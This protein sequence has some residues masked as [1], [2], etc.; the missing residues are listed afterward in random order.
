MSERFE[1]LDAAGPLESVLSLGD[2]T[3]YFPEHDGESRRRRFLGRGMLLVGLVVAAC[4]PATSGGFLWTDDALLAQVV[5]LRTADGLRPIWL[6]PSSSLPQRP[7]AMTLVWAEHRFCGADAGG[8]HLVSLLLHAAN[9]LLAWLVLRRLAVPGAWLAAAAWS[10]HPIQVQSLASVSDQGTVLSTFLFLTAGLLFLRFHDVQPPWPDDDPDATA[11][12]ELPHPVLRRAV[13]YAVAVIVFSAALAAGSVAE[14]MPAV[15][16]LVLWWRRGWPGRRKAATTVAAI[17]P[18]FVLTGV[19]VWL[20]GHVGPDDLAEGSA[21]TSLIARLGNI[22]HAFWFYLCKLGWPAGLRVAYPGWQDGTAAGMAGRWL[23]VAAAAGS[24]TTAW[25]FRRRLGEG[26]LVAVVF[27]IAALACAAG[28]LT[29][30][31]HRLMTDPVAYLAV[32]GPIA[33]AVAALAWL[34]GGQLAAQ[35]QRVARLAAVAAVPLVLALLTW[36]RGGTFPDES[37]LW[38]AVLAA[39]PDAPAAAAA[40]RRLGL[41]LLARGQPAAAVDHL[42][43]AVEFNPGHVGAML[44]LAHSLDA[45]GRPDEAVGVF[46]DTPR[47]TPDARIYVALAALEW[48]TGRPD[49]ALRHYA[50]ALSLRPRDA[51]LH[52]DIGVILAEQGRPDEAS[53]HYHAAIRLEPHLAQARINL[54]NVLFRQGRPD[55]AAAQLHEAVRIDPLNFEAFANAA[56][57]LSRYKDYPRAEQM[58]RAAVAVRPDV[59]EAWNNLGIALAAQGQLSEAVYTFR[60]ALHLRPDFTQARENLQRAAAQQEQGPPRRRPG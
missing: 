44:E 46:T 52:N 41:I 29:P 51:A 42:R 47:R 9:G 24:V 43:R 32:L 28:L 53:W 45:A 31:T 33:L 5:P 17:A 48:R 54:A 50:D 34:V 1:N 26:P 13:L 37:S 35:R 6:H 25:A 18:L 4:L 22:G 49:Q 40:H 12:D 3:P 11:G 59:P 14:A 20:W 23:P 10:L 15:L 16:A 60:R 21:P 27:Y 8:Y 57:M 58:L 56:A 39:R 36:Q 19:A 55:D 30:P 38:Q 7:L 2:D